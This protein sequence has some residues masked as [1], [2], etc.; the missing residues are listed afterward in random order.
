LFSG[1][2]TRP[3]GTFKEAAQTGAFAT[4]KLNYGGHPLGTEPSFC[5]TG[6][7][8]ASQVP[9]FRPCVDG[10]EEERRQLCYKHRMQQSVGIIRIRSFRQVGKYI[11]GGQTVLLL[12]R[13]SDVRLHAMT[14]ECRLIEAMEYKE[15]IQ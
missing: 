1:L 5:L 6:P 2:T 4:V 9:T 13:R 12:M 11:F 3:Y 14:V 8:A 15:G 10:T 7:A